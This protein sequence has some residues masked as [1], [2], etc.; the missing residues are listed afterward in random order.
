MLD[1]PLDARGWLNYYTRRFPRLWERAE[2]MRYRARNNL[3][4]AALKWEKWC[5]LPKAAWWAALEK[6]GLEK[7]DIPVYLNIAAA[8]GA[9]R[10]T[11]G[12]YTFHPAL[13]AALIETEI[14][15][16][17]PTNILTR[18]PEWCVYVD[19]EGTLGEIR[20]FWAYLDEYNQARELNYLVNL[21]GRIGSLPPII[22]GEWSVDEGLRRAKMPDTEEFIK[23]V[24]HLYHHFT[25]VVLYV[26]SSEP[27]IKG[28]EAPAYPA[29][30]KVK[31]GLKLFPPDKPRYY[32]YGD[33]IGAKIEAAER[34]QK[35]EDERDYP[36]TRKSVRP[37]IR[38]AHWH[39]FWRG[40]RQSQDREID[41]KWLYPML[42]NVEE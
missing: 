9:W 39:S 7:N 28:G 33:I 24:A 30:K 37:H 27:D 15:G 19:F 36:H 13:A 22:L 11:Q 38:R 17:L 1:T 20:G 10:W 40:K 41:V 18:M 12:I 14:K 8:L 6:C 4:D 16:D 23:S 3:E 21:G 5:Y 31:R 25:S 2:F 34:A 32:R 42:I 29:Y 35:E 26:C